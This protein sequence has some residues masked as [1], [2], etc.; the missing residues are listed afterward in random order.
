MVI[1]IDEKLSLFDALHGGAEALGYLL[2]Q[3]RDITI[4]ARLA[5]RRPVGSGGAVVS[6][7]L[8]LVTVLIATGPPS[9]RLR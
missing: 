3:A 1:D 9:G 6:A 2:F 8:R 5:L 4:G 7:V